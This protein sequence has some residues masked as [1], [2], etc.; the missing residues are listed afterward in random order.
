ML[1]FSSLPAT[2]LV[3][4][5]WAAAPV[6]SG[7]DQAGDRAA[8]VRFLKDHVDGKTLISPE[9]VIR[10][11]GGKVESV[12]SSRVR[13]CNFTETKSGFYFDAQI[14]NKQ[15]VYDL[16]TE[17]KRLGAGR[18]QDQT[19]TWR[20]Q[21]APRRSTHQLVGVAVP[22]DDKGRMVDAGDPPFSA[23]AVRMHMKEVKL[24]LEQSTVLHDDLF[25]KAGK[26]RPGFIEVE[27]VFAVRD[28]R[29]E[30]T[31]KA[32]GHDVDPRTQKKKLSDG[33]PERVEKQVD[34]KP[35]K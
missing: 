23:Y 13:F 10:S 24:H 34:D 29:L 25:A 5:I 16:D 32:K 21:V 18:K 26:W 15:T 35:E 22:V 33:L 20:Y 7:E 31:V 27:S 14:T 12:N 19:F 8:T 3:V 17:G 11:D 9:Q 28:G 30:R 1:Q 2:G 6:T 4:T